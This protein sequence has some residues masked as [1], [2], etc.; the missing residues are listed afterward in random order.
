MTL[1]EKP[2]F[3]GR[4]KDFTDSC[5]HLLDVGFDKTIMDVSSV[6]SIRGVYVKLLK[7]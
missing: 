6:K 2:N 1:Y 3:K 7:S 5:P 4:S